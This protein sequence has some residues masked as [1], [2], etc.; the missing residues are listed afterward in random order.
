MARE[1]KR[2]IPRVSATTEK[3]N[4]KS[5]FYDTVIDGDET[6]IGDSTMTTNSSELSYNSSGYVAGVS[7]NCNGTTHRSSEL[8]TSNKSKSESLNCTRKSGKKSSDKKR[9]SKKGNTD[10]FVTSDGSFSS[11]KRTVKGE[12]KDQSDNVDMYDS[13]LLNVTGND[14]QKTTRGNFLAESTRISFLAQNFSSSLMNF[15]KTFNRESLSLI[16][17]ES[18]GISNSNDK[19]L[20]TISDDSTLMILDEGSPCINT[21]T[22]TEERDDK[23]RT[24]YTQDITMI[25]DKIKPDVGKLFE[26]IK[27]VVNDFMELR[28]RNGRSLDLLDLECF[29]I[30][31]KLVTRKFLKEYFESKN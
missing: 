4:I 27:I 22:F 30:S 16:K 10:S 9:S 13:T 7:S 5:V 25:P 26:M 28:E 20:N 11:T 3:K 17:E 24:N 2:S 29:T 14:I 31:I 18:E 23:T 15:K 21:V 19:S 6:T 8:S 12:N 1:A